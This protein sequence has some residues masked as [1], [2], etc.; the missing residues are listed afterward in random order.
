MKRRLLTML[1]ILLLCSMVW[2]VVWA[3]GPV[4][5][6]DLPGG[7]WITGTQVQ[8]VGTG[9]A[10]IVMTVYGQTSGQ[11]ELTETSV[12]PNASVNFLATSFGWP[13]G[14]IGSAIVSSDQPIVAQTTETNGTAAAQY[15]GIDEPDT[16][17]NFPLVKNNYLGGGKYTTFFVQNAG[18]SAAIIYAMYRAE[19]GTTYPWNS[20]SAVDPGRMVALNPTDVSFPTNQLGSLVVTSTVPIAGVVNEH[21]VTEGIILQATRGFAPADAGTT[22]LIP[23]IKRQLGSRSTGPIIQNVSNGP[24]NI[25]ITYQG[26]GISFQQYANNVPAGASVTFYENTEVCPAG[27]TCGRT[28]TPLPV[29]TLASAV[30]VGTGNIVGVVNETFYTIPSGQRQRQ[31][32][33]SAF[34]QADA[35]TKI[36]VPLYKVNHDYKNSGVQLQ[37]TNL[38]TAAT[39]TAT[40]SLGGSGGVP[41]TNYVLRGTIN[42]GQ[43][44]TLF[45]LYAALP[46]GS[47]WVGSGFPSAWS[48]SSTSPERF[49]SVTIVA[50]Q[51]IV[52]AVTEADDDPVVG[53]RQDIK[54]YEGF[55]LTP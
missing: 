1:A 7:G 6:Q 12:A 2:G 53:D 16:Q 55:S 20:G 52:A 25:T 49:G 14:S 11:W 15:Q 27:A 51:P 31:T 8:N 22:L 54:S 3:Q 28:G 33:T 37:N 39:Y 23:T 43:Y 50:D 47:S 48:T 24:V 36:G 46:P 42:P 4:G 13:D 10:I 38:A 29:G 41:V 17:V 30:V 35:T 9:N 19:D 40:F 5:P 32:V 18:S 44:V 21:H 34:N 45:K 26:T